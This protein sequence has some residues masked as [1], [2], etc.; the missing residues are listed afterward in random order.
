MTATG[1]EL[2]TLNQLKT[3]G[4]HVAYKATSFYT[5]DDSYDIYVPD[6]KSSR[7]IDDSDKWTSFLFSETRQI[8]DLPISEGAFSQDQIT[9]GYSDSNQD[10][11]GL[12]LSYSS[13]QQGHDSQSSQNVVSSH[14]I[15]LRS[16]QEIN[17]ESS[18]ST[19]RIRPNTGIDIGG[20]VVGYLGSLSCTP[21]SLTFDVKEGTGSD[22]TYHGMTIRS[23][24]AFKY[25]VGKNASG[26]G[27]RNSECSMPAADEDVSEY[28]SE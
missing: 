7:L 16:R 10:F 1:N 5:P 18:S 27:N 20:V 15:D 22:A 28:F 12:G 13:Y 17:G 26:I 24:G 9:I 23:N 3:Y 8:D 11:P 6:W 21:A 25:S 2:V 4:G 14:S 19:I